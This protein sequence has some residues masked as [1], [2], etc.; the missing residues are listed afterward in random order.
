MPSEAVAFSALGPGCQALVAQ[1]GRVLLRTTF[2]SAD[3]AAGAKFA[4]AAKAVELSLAPQR[5]PQRTIGAM[6]KD[7]NT[8]NDEVVSSIG[9]LWRDGWRCVKDAEQ[10]RLRFMRAACHGP[11]GEL[12]NIR[13]YQDFVCVLRGWHA[14]ARG[15]PPSKRPANPLVAWSVSAAEGLG[16]FMDLSWQPASVDD[17]SDDVWLVADE[18]ETVLDTLIVA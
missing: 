5:A 16:A 7:V 10:H 9:Q 6:L 17:V 2:W 13:S 12:V 3:A 4:Q 11:S 15:Q 8:M 18:N 1:A 14:A